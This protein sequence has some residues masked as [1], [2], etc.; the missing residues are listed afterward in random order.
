MARFTVDIPD[1]LNDWLIEQAE[2]DNRSKNKQIVYL[3]ERARVLAEGVDKF[4]VSGFQEGT[5]IEAG[6]DK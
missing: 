6:R 1:D 4:Q 5:W 2:K 3:L